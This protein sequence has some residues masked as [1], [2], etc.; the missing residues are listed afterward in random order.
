MVFP[1]SGQV[2]VV[3]AGAGATVAQAA[4]PALTTA[5]RD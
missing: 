5:R 2:V 3:R 4:A 1:E